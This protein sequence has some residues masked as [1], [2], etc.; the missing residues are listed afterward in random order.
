MEEE[1]GDSS[2]EEESQAEENEED[3]RAMEASGLTIGQGYFCKEFKVR[4]GIEEESATL[5]REWSKT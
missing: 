2:T 5:R 1:E 4:N 3:P